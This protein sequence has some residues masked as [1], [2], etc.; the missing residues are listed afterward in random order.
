MVKSIDIL[1]DKKIAAFYHEVDKQNKVPF[2][3]G[4]KHV[5]NVYHIMEKLCDAFH[6]SNMEREA[7]LIAAAL[8]DVGQ[9]TGR[10]NHGFK[11]MEFS[12]E[13]LLQYKD[14]LGEYYDL[15]L[16]AIEHHSSKDDMQEYPLFVQMLRFADKMDFTSERLEDNYRDR[17]DYFISED[18]SD[19]NF[20]Y[21][22]TFI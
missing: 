18:I 7:L 21:G 13:Y 14:E 5:R 9:V 16:L 20:S 10:D 19:V 1:N 8:H 4:H 11:S 3:H 6:I 17:F 15:I 22:D 2:S 12:R